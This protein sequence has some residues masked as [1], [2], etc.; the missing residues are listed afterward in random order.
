VARGR[1]I[2][3]CWPWPCPRKSAAVVTNDISCPLPF[4]PPSRDVKVF[5]ERIL[6]PR[7][8]CALHL[9]LIT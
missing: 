2:Y 4:L 1:I 3:L 8:P 5:G 9:A 6:V 7:Q